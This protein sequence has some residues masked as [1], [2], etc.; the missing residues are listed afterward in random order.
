M[1]CCNETSLVWKE[2]GEVWPY[3]IWRC[4]TCNKEYSVELVRDFENKEELK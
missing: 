4:V 2:E 3:E 1:E